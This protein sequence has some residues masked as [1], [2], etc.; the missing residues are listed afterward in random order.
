[1][2]VAFSAAAKDPHTRPY[3]QRREFFAA[4]MSSFLGSAD[5]CGFVSHDFSVHQPLW[6]L[7]CFG[8]KDSRAGRPETSWCS[9]CS[10][11]L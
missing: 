8:R 11:R 9:P 10:D 4:L 7:R 1:M 2:A 3:F 5:V 6:Y